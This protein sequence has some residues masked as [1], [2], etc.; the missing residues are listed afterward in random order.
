MQTIVS[1]QQN[2]S[3]SCRWRTNSQV[4]SAE[5]SER[6][7]SGDFVFGL[8]EEGREIRSN[9]RE[10]TEAVPEGESRK[11]REQHHHWLCLAGNDVPMG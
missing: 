8:D 11:V 7:I 2:A 10:G 1:E 4:W 3:G 9:L 5:T 6:V